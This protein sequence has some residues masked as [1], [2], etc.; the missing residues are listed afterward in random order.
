MCVC[1]CVGP[2]DGTWSPRARVAGGCEMA[3][4]CVGNGTV[5]P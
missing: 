3:Y 2:E 1:F 4:M 5:V